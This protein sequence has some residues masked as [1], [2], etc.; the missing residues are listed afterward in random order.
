MPPMRE[1]VTARQRVKDDWAGSCNMC[2]LPVLFGENA[3]FVTVDA[4]DTRWHGD[5]R[6]YHA[7]C[8]QPDDAEG[9]P[10]AG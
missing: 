5:E 10:D 4:P 2:E 3:V 9:D 6:V 1:R 8:Y 7:D